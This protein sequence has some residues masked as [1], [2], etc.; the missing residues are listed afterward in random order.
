M[1]RAQHQKRFQLTGKEFALAAV[2]AFMGLAFTSR[3]FLLWMNGLTPLE[4]LIIYYMIL[5]GALYVLG[6]LGLVIFNIK[7]DDS[8]QTLG[9][10]LITFAFFITV[11]MTSA[12]VQ[13]VTT[14]TLTGMSNL[15][16]QDE[17]GACF[18]IFQQLLP[19]AGITVWYYLT[20][21]VTPFVL[22][23][24]GG[25]LVTEKIRLSA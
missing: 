1:S 8:Q 13:Y 21:A 9:L 6:Q 23:L 19:W 5:Y 4:G 24:L 7:I 16:L 12:Y 10:L 2:F 17:D 15:F 14:G 22:A 20:Y 11:D 25:C 18:F 3:P